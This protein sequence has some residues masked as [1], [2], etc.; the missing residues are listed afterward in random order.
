MVNFI[1]EIYEQ[2]GR[3]M[4]KWIYSILKFINKELK[5]NRQQYAAS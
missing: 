5:R 1:P 3:I 2:K 4:K